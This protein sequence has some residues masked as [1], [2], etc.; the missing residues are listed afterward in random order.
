M[1]AFPFNFDRVVE[2]ARMKLHMGIKKWG[3]LGISV[4]VGI[5]L[6]MTGAWTGTL[7]AWVLGVS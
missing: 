2:R 6:P 4:F 5:L 3:W 7:E 1:L